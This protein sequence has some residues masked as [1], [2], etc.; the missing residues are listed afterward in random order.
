MT[1]DGLMTSFSFCSQ[2]SAYLTRLQR[3]KEIICAT[4]LL[5][6]W[7]MLTFK[8]KFDGNQCK[9]IGIFCLVGGSGAPLA[10]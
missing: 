5:E 2:Y 9:I 3:L 10:T 6:G 7:H 1:M 4:D 8:R